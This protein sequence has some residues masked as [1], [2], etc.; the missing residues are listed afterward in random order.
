M[1]EKET[2][3]IE[4]PGTPELIL[5]IRKLDRI[6]TTGISRSGGDNGSN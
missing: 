1:E 3:Q 4:E 5:Q 6:E 2:K